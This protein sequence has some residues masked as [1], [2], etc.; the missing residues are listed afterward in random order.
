MSSSNGNVTGVRPCI[1]NKTVKGT[2]DEN[3]KAFGLEPKIEGLKI[4]YKDNANNYSVH[5]N[6][7]SEKN[8]KTKNILFSDKEIAINLANEIISDE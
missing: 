3:F 6:E 8:V 4:F 7:K 5:E 2:S 1:D